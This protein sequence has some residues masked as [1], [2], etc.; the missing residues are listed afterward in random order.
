MN[1]VSRRKS[2][3][4]AAVGIVRQLYARLGTVVDFDEFL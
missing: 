3:N 4:V 1:L 2:S